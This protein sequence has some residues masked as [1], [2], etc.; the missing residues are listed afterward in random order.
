MTMDALGCLPAKFLAARGFKFLAARGYRKFCS[1]GTSPGGF[2]M[3]HPN[4]FPGNRQW[5][6]DDPTPYCSSG[7]IICVD[8]HFQRWAVGGVGGEPKSAWNSAMFQ[9]S[10]RQ[11][12]H[13]TLVPQKVVPAGSATQ[14]S[15]YLQV[16]R[17]LLQHLKISQLS[18][19]NRLKM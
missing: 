7:W 12:L 14:N 18:Q 8:F 11:S 5:S 3:C 13:A 6:A 10:G 4:R 17:G 15:P 16:K 2:V 1:G 9:D 19:V